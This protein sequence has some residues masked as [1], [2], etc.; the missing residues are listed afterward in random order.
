MEEYK[1]VDKLGG[2]MT[3]EDVDEEMMKTADTK[4]DDL[5]KHLE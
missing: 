5:Y 4:V 2:Q 3:I 1:Y